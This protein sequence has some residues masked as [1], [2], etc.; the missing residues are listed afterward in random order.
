MLCA[1]QIGALA[2]L[3]WWPGA[4]FPGWGLALFGIAFGAYAGAGWASTAVTI[5]VW[6][7]WGA[8]I[9]MRLLFLP[10]EPLSTTTTRST[11]AGIS[12]ST[13]GSEPSSFSAG[14]TIEIVEQAAFRS[15]GRRRP[16][17]PFSGGDFGM[18]IPGK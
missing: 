17:I 10:L 11:D 6:V 4:V 5:P 8:A 13:R 15:E 7:L 16:C 18:R 2:A 14:I 1:V 9:V 3:G 12:S